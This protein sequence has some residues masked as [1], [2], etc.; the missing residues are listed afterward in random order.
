MST[1]AEGVETPAQLAALR[2]SGC[3]SVQ[4]YL[5]SRPMPAGQ[6]PVMLALV[7]GLA[8]RPDHRPVPSDSVS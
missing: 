8:P 6:V 1:I 5:L 7:Q 4:G 2:S 3:D